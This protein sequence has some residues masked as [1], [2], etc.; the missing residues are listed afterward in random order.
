VGKLTSTEAVHE[1]FNEILMEIKRNTG[2]Y[3]LAIVLRDGLIVASLM[4]EDLD[5]ETLAAMTA[6]IIKAAETVFTE[7]DKGDVKRIIIEG[8]HAKVVAVTAGKDFVI[9][10][11][12]NP[13]TSLGIILHS[14]R[15]AAEKISQRAR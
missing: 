6:T 5:E 2:I 15:K 9:V 8:T 12:A 10:G 14:M 3:A 11:M 13:E 4:P 7:L 1:T